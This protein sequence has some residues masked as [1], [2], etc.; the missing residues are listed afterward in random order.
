MFV[1]ATG[2]ETAKAT[3]FVGP[4]ALSWSVMGLC[5][6]RQSSNSVSADVRNHSSEGYT[7]REES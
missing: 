4:D 6:R 3:G 7:W 5:A 1:R 2:R